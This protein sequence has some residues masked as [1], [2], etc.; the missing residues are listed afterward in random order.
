MAEY[1]VKKLYQSTAPGVSEEAESYESMW[2]YTITYP[3]ATHATPGRFR[4][5]ITKMGA[6]E[7]VA[8]MGGN[9]EDV[10]DQAF[11][12]Q[13]Y[14]EKWSSNG[15]ISCLDWMG[16]P[17]ATN[18]EIESDLCDMFQSFTTGIPSHGTYVGQPPSP[19]SPEPPEE[20]PS[21]P[22][23]VING[24]NKTTKKAT[25]PKPDDTFEFV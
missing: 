14:L 15:W 25:K 6:A 16:N 24:G 9:P 19:P 7:F 4:I 2:A 10:P 12:V 20:K 11:S 23:S 18:P 13:A 17:E 3:S 5:R 22:F 1:R 21:K 8:M